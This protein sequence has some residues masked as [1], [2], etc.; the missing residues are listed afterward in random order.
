MAVV[1]DKLV[2]VGGCSKEFYVVTNSLLTLSIGLFKVWREDLP[3]MRS[4]R[5]DP[6]FVST[7]TFLVVA[8]GRQ[9]LS[10]LSLLSTVEVLNLKTRTWFYS[11]SLPQ[12]E[13]L[14]QLTIC[15]E[16]IFISSK[17]NMYCSSVEDLLDSCKPAYGDAKPLWSRL[18]NIPVSYGS[19]LVTLRGH[20]LAVGGANQ[21][22]TGATY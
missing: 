5:I 7:P 11:S 20:V 9:T 13:S 1:G 18:A 16:R 2:F 21:L 12:M 22:P 15:N 6:A 10:G 3:P 4:I 14:P 17:N 8:G 19:S